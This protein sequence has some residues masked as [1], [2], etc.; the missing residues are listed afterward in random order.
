MKTDEYLKE[1]LRGTGLTEAPAAPARPPALAE[2]FF[3]PA[4][5]PDG[6]PE[7]MAVAGL[8]GPELLGLI[9]GG[10]KRGDLQTLSVAGLRA[11]LIS[12]T[13]RLE[14]YEQWLAE[15]GEALVERDRALADRERD[16]A[17][18]QREL[19]RLRDSAAGRLMK[20]GGRLSSGGRRLKNRLKKDG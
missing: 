3:A 15:R 4:W 13:R 17:E 6:I 7:G 8:T 11:E 18:R 16:L 10:L 5:E 12:M 14:V 20:A 19:K 2:G 9:A 1:Y